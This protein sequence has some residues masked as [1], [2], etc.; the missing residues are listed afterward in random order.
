MVTEINKIIS[1]LDNPRFIS[2]P[3]ITKVEIMKFLDITMVVELKN[4]LV[5]NDSRY[6][7]L[8]ERCNLK[9][10]FISQKDL[11]RIFFY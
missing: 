4:C 11:G 9:N 6:I 5:K 2:K 8:S 10:N 7:L 1:R 3:L